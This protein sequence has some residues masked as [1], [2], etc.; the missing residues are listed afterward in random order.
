MDAMTKQQCGTCRF[1]SEMC[2]QAMGGGPIEAL[3][4]SQTGSKAMK[5]TTERMS[6]EA[7]KSGHH[8]A[9]D[10]PPN[11]GEHAVASY[12]AEERTA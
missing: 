6:C 10:S 4:L 3:C 12:E 9:V 5:Y 2:A 8:G 11:Y 1:W 7:W